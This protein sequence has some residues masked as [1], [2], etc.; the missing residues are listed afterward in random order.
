VL[1]GHSHFPARS[2]IGHVHAVNIGSG[3]RWKTWVG[4]DL[5]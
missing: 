3:Y 1:C 2:S 5:P 4:L